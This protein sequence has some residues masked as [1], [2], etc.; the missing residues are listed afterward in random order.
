MAVGEGALWAVN[1]DG[2][3]SRVDPSS[4]DVVATIRGVDVNT[5]TVGEGAVWTANIDRTVSRIDPAT[6]AIDATIEVASEGL[7]GIAAGAGAIWVT[8]PVGGVV[9]R[10][11][12]GGA[13]AVQ[14]TIA[15]EPGVVGI[16]FGEGSVWVANPLEGTISRIDPSTDR[17]AETLDVGNAPFNVAVGEGSVWVTVGQGGAPP[18]EEPEPT[19][20]G[21]VALPATSCGELEGPEGAGL[22][23]TSDLP[24]QGASQAQN[25]SIEAAVRH[26]LER[27]DFRAGEHA[28]AYQSCDDSTAQAGGWE[29]EKCAANFQAYA[30][31]PAVVAVIG[32]YNS[33]CSQIAIPFAN[34]APGSPLPMISP[35]N[36]YLGL[37][38]PTPSAPPR[39]LERLYPTGMRNYLRVYPPTDAQAAALAQ[40][41]QELGLRRVFVLEDQASGSYG[42]D[43]AELFEQA[44]GQLGVGL[45]GRRRWDAEAE[46]Y[47][48]VA[49]RV[50]AADPDGVLLSGYVYSNA[51]RLIE[52]L[53]AELGP[54]VVLLAPD[55][56]SRISDLM[57]IVGPLANG[58]YVSTPGVPTDSLASDRVALLEELRAAYPDLW[59]YWALY[60]AQTTEV[61]LD[62]IA[63]S[64]GTRASVLEEL[65]ATEVENGIT[66]SFGF[67]EN[68]D[69]TSASIV[70]LRV[71]GTG[72]GI[73]HLSED[74]AEGSTVE[75]VIAP[76]LAL[77][78]S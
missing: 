34:R 29:A 15:L 64:N 66:G 67:D 30:E 35:S 49:Q 59:D 76:D 53:R 41:A 46:S 78:R 44:A 58:M 27:N 43:L 20:G 7:S 40:L 10:I 6:N 56:F 57:E 4:G 19:E 42:Y 50:A 17:V 9:W 3:V 60:G 36:D 22:L 55:G 65:F 51:G 38:R 1:P 75:R 14:K 21:I 25:A 45:A 73:S 69:T 70:I 11:D 71:D 48:V 12:P 54:D 18:A 26:V 47:R 8:D 13:R 2:T 62:A 16:A 63:R 39:E 72:P 37:T 32:A 68:G 61:L 5:L 77:V 28:L 23:V 24:L 33:G 52:D 31:N 74:F